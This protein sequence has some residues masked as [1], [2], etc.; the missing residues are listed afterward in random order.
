MAFHYPGA[1]A[2]NEAR[3]NHLASLNLPFSG[4]TVFETGAGARGDITRW[5]CQQGALVTVNDGRQDCIDELCHRLSDYKD[6]IVET[7]V[8]D[9]NTFVPSSS[10]D[11][12]VSY[13][14]LY[15]LS[16]PAAFLKNFSEK[17]NKYFVLST[18]VDPREQT[19]VHFMSE[20]GRDQAIDGIG[21]RPTVS[22]ILN[23][24]G[25]YFPHVEKC[26]T[27][28]L[29]PDFQENW[30]LPYNVHNAT[31]AVFLAWR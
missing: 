2:I 27:Q 28:P 17:C 9:L 31:R 13:G 10:Y 14:L 6:N 19:T 21:C 8:S 4:A 26:S 23:E 1:V 29:F 12:I 20:N 22:W 25:K 3:I 30:N 24:L 7:N 18:C 15:H 5:L 16:S 11:F